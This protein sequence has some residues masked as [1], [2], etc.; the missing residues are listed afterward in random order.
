VGKDEAWLNG[1]LKEKGIQ[2]IGDV[3][4]AAL[5]SANRL[6]LTLGRS[7]SEEPGKYGIE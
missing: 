6:Y 7:V 2:W 1:Q 3:L 4:F 5:D